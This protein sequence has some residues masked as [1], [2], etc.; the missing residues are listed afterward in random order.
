MLDVSFYDTEEL[1]KNVFL[2]GMPRNHAVVR[3]LRR[4]SGRFQHNIFMVSIP[5]LENKVS[6]KYS[7]V[8]RNSEKMAIKKK[9]PG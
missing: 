7:S 6:G 1:G 4:Q 2:F 5:T 8:N 9:R 3:K